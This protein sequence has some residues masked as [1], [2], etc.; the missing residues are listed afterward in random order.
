[1]KKRVVVT[2]LGVVSP[3]A[4][5]ISEFETA[6]RQGRSG[7][8]FI[9]RLAELNFGCT[10]GGIPEGVDALL[11]KR[12][13]QKQ[14]R[15]TS[16]NIGYAA[17]SALDAWLD[18]GLAVDENGGETDWHA[19]AVVGC[20]IGDMTTIAERI[21]PMIN[22]GRVR[23]IG[24]RVIEQ[25][26]NSGI[27]ARIGGLLGL[28]NQVTSNS[29]ACNTGTEAIAA[30]LFRIRDGHA[31]RMVAGG[32]EAASPYTWGGF[33]SMRILARKFNDAPEKGSR[34]MS[35]AA[36]GF[37]PGAGAGI[38]VLEELESALERGAGIYAEVLGGCVNS[39]GQRGG[40]SMTA[41]NPEG[42]KR[43]IRAAVR[44]AGIHPYDIDAVNGHLTATYADTQEIK[45]WSEVLQR[46]PADFPWIN[47]TKSMIGHCLGAAGAIETVAA[48]IELSSGFLHPSI[49][50]EDVHPE[51]LPFADKIVQ[52][53]MADRPVNIIAKASFGFGDVN[54]C[55]I[56]KKWPS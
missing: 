5:T 42:V 28:G 56:L 23:K 26:M 7:I 13:N 46:G 39:G 4:N 55:L 3:N 17:V 44:D 12:F 24:S 20:G 21:V 1:M 29:S 35:A 19:G 6:L 14:L 45:N 18:A 27:S 53:H 43:C 34:P 9:P 2:G 30:A 51:L 10:I 50:C 54:G 49:N 15:D 11:E 47:S 36:C 33:D 52:R 25:A 41:P 37:V 31:K 48:V 40:G 8:R 32:S 38:L 22:A 16:Y